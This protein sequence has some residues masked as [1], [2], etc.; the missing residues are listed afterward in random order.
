M[1]I[2]VGRNPA[3]DRTRAQRY[4]DGK[5]VRKRVPRT[6]HALWAAAKGRPDPVSI[7]ENS[8]RTRVPYLV[9]IWY[10]RMSLSPF[11]FFRGSASIMAQDLATTP[12][13]G[14]RAQLCGDAH[15]SNFGVFATPERDRV[16]DINDFDETLPG[17]WEWDVKRLATS[18]VLVGRLNGFSPG[19]NRKAVRTA[20]RVYRRAMRWF[21]GARYLDTWYAHLDRHAESKHFPRAGQELISEAVRRARR[22]TG[23]HAF[24]KLVQSVQGRYKIR[25]DPPLIVHYQN[26]ADIEE[27][28]AF[29][30]RY[31][32]TLT[33]DRRTLLDR[34]HLVDVAQKVVGVGSVGTICAVILLMGD[35]DVEDPL[36][37]QLK[38]ANAS[39]LEPH[40]GPSRFENHAERVVTGQ[41]LIQESSDIFLGWSRLHSRDFYL[42]QLR[43]MKFTTDVT[44]LRPNA[45]LGQADLCGVALARAHARTGDPAF[46]SGYLGNRD[47]FDKAIAA[48]AEQYADQVGQDHAALV[49]AIR[50]GKIAAQVDV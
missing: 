7:L 49:R 43:D 20:L 29:F 13:T 6:S 33:D 27:S 42:R 47:V 41:R 19:T 31:R 50:R 40:A 30:D 34:Y 28:Q 48:F 5:A 35:R 44:P 26:P 36:F 22:R 18:L 3:L 14:A 45:L 11:S 39:V 25:D 38:Q 21:G 1:A 15:F 32:S 23:F 8:S 17:P 9:P 4:A 16:F 12:T 37:L 24:P 46:I 10:G 2:S